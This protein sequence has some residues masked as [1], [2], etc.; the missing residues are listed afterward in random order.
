MNK[1]EMA[2]KIVALVQRLGGGVSFVEMQ[3]ECGPESQGEL[4]LGMGV[5]GTNV[6][7]WAGC[8]ELFIDAFSI[9]RDSLDGTPTSLLI[10][11][12]D[13]Q[14]LNWPLAMRVPK[15]G[16][17]TPHWMPMSFKLKKERAYD[18]WNTE[19]NGRVVAKSG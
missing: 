19:R 3:R 10:Y 8:S 7:L 6:Y 13:G 12:V 4:G 17:K 18:P 9:A 11:L 1:Q 15:K 16:Y 5:E 14:G 2:D